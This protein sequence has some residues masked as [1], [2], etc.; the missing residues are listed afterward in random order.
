MEG[1]RHGQKFFEA[2]KGVTRKKPVVVLKSGRSKA[3]ARAASSHS[4]SL[5][6]DDQ[7]FD[8]LLRQSGAVRAES[9]DDLVDLGKAFAYLPL[10]SGDR[11]SCISLSGGAGVMAADALEKNGLSLE[12]LSD[13]TLSVVR[14][15]G[16]V[17]AI[18][19]NPLDIEPLSETVGFVD[20]YTLGLNA[21]LS[22][23][24]VHSCIV[25][26]GTMFRSEDEIQFVLEAMERHPDKPIAVCILGTQDIYAELF[27]L[28]EKNKIPVYPTVERAARALGEL[29]RRRRYLVKFGDVTD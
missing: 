27:V 19:S 24:K 25:Q 28:Y 3:G 29:N 18:P 6:G 12:E 11:T 13:E 5:A 16:P 20:A 23:N 22:D 2:L 9:L 15:K 17:W 8:A 7:I 14:E 10:P 4:A 26:H 1:T 21:L